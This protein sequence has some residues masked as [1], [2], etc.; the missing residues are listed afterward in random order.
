MHTFF[1]CF[2]FYGMD[3]LEF[4]DNNLNFRKWPLKFLE[5]GFVAMPLIMSSH[6]L[7]S[8]ILT[9][10][11]NIVIIGFIYTKT[12]ILTECMC[13]SRLIPLKLLTSSWV[14]LA[15]VNWVTFEKQ[16]LQNFQY[17]FFSLIISLF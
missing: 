9:N 5:S 15:V 1:Y 2:F 3:I 6:H 4:L 14:P 16:M 13:N 8:E 12:H 7:H 11:E 17:I 10:R